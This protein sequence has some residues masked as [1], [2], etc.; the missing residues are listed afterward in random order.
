MDNTIRFGFWNYVESGVLKKEEVAEWKKMHFDLPMSFTFDERKHDKRDMLAL[1]DEC[2]KY[3]LK[4]IICDQRTHFRTLLLEDRDKFIAGVKQAY[5]DFGTHGA[6]FGF[7]V[8]D[9]PAPNETEIFIEAVKIVIEEMPG[10]T[11]FANLVPYWGGGSDFD[12][13]VGASEREHTEIV[14]KILK[15]T[16]IPLIGY[17]QYTQCLDDNYNTEC[18]INSYFYVLDQYHKLTKKYGIPFYVT[19]LSCGHWSFR[20]PREEDIRWQIY[21][22]LAHGAR[23]ILWFHLYGYDAGTSYVGNP[24]VLCGNDVL[25]TPLYDAILRQQAIFNAYYRS[26]F[27]KM[28]MTAV[29]HTGHIYD[30]QKRFCA[31][32][33][34]SDINGKFSYP[35]IITYYKE[36]ITEKKWISVVNAHQRHAN[37]I[38]LKYANGKEESFWL[39]AGEMRLIDPEKQKR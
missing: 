18:G 2:E 9:E 20:T 14:E 29:Y 27:E 28:E 1:L 7:F 11:P 22:A 38:T 10:L 19:L 34:L 5:T 37:R 32:D 36:Y 3:G 33:M 6:A 4:L 31:D 8:G 15:E 30:P 35:T 12:M 24:F 13:L 25:K 21:T 23:G 17:D 39:A 26:Q 16:K